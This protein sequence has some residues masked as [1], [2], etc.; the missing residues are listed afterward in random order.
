MRDLLVEVLSGLVR[1]PSINPNYPGCVYEELVG[2][3]TAANEF[4]AGHYADAGLKVSWV[5]RDKGRANLVGVAAGSGG[6]GAKSLALNGHVDV[7]PPGDLSQWT[8]G[9]PFSGQ[10]ADGRVYG[11]G[12]VDMKGGL[13]AALLAAAAL[14]HAG[15]GLEGD[16]ILHSVAGEETG[17]HDVGVNAVIEAGFGGD[18][19]IVG[20]G[21][22]KFFV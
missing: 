2:G 8:T 19:A 13:V 11:R 10:V 7:V 4:L 1:I 22:V 6:S 21:P 14:Q 20:E 12:A 17:D 15:V 3:E 16:L 18:A 9:D 5:E